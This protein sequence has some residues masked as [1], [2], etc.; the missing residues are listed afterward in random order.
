MPIGFGLYSHCASP[1]A[2]AFSSNCHMC[3]TF[4]FTVL[5]QIF[6]VANEDSWRDCTNDWRAGII[7]SICIFTVVCFCW[8]FVETTYIPDLYDP[9]SHKQDRDGRI[10]MSATAKYKRMKGS[11]LFFLQGMEEG[12]VAQPSDWVISFLSAATF[13]ATAFLGQPFGPCVRVGQS[14][15][16]LVTMV[17]FGLAILA[18]AVSSGAHFLDPRT[19]MNQ[20]SM[21]G[22]LNSQPLPPA[23]GGSAD[24][25]KVVDIHTGINDANLGSYPLAY[26][27]PTNNCTLQQGTNKGSISD[28]D[29]VDSF[30]KTQKGSTTSSS[31]PDLQAGAQMPRYS[32]T[33]HAGSTLPAARLQVFPYPAQ[34]TS[35]ELCSSQAV[36]CYVDCFDLQPAPAAPAHG[37]EPK[38]K[39]AL[40]NDEDQVDGAC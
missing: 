24:T 4:W 7:G 12:R 22:T 16:F 33:Q 28:V 13:F 32:A 2:Y 15:Q 31:I 14:S 38:R 9:S 21:V 19:S 36:E 5:T 26:C 10:E 25:A 20:K 6:S 23:T 30:A 11:P 37:Y 3:S 8:G 27:H 29:A 18:A 35:M 40:S 17:P 39:F 1:T 34:V